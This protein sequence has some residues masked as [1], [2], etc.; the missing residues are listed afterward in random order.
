MLGKTEAC[1]AG[2]QHVRDSLIDRNKLKGWQLSVSF[3]TVYFKSTYLKKLISIFNLYNHASI[4][5]PN[6]CKSVSYFKGREAVGLK[7]QLISN[8]LYSVHP[9]KGL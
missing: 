3:F 1:S 7:K 6:G 2:E 9:N 4:S 8:R 5:S